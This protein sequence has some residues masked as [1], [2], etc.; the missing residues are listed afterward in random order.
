VGVE[1]LPALIDGRPVGVASQDLSPELLGDLQ[2]PAHAASPTLGEPVLL[3][4]GGHGLP[5]PAGERREVLR[6][7]ADS[8]PHVAG[9]RDRNSGGTPTGAHGLRGVASAAYL[10]AVAFVDL[11]LGPYSVGRVSVGLG[12]LRTAVLFGALGDVL[13]ALYLLVAA[14]RVR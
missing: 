5:V 12:D 7:H 3:L 1:I 4:A 10:V 14:A 9:A 13:G 11:A 2:A 6:L 8:V